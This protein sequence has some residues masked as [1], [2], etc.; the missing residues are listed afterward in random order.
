MGALPNGF[1]WA[2]GATP[3]PVGVDGSYALIL[4]GPTGT[5][6]PAGSVQTTSAL[7]AEAT[8]DEYPDSPEIERSEQATFTH[9][10][11]M[12][13][14]E[15]MN[16][17]QWYYRG[18]YLYDT[19]GNIYVCLSARFQRTKGGMCDVT[20]VSEAKNFDS[21]PDELEI[22]PVELGLNIMKHPRYF[23]AFLGDGYGSTT[24]KNNQQVIRLLQDYF[25]NP[26]W[27]NRNAIEGILVRSLSDTSYTPGTS[28][29]TSKEI[30]QY[31]RYGQPIPN[32]KI[33]GTALAKHAA[34]EIIQKYWRGEETPYIAGWQMTFSQYFFLPPFLHPGGVIQDPI[35]SN[36]VPDYLTSPSWPPN[37]AYQ[38]FDLM[39]QLNPQCYSSNGTVSGTS[40]ISW[41][42]K[43]DE[44][45]RQR[46]W[47][48]L[49]KTWIGTPVGYWDPDFYA[50]TA[51]PTL[52]VHYRGFKELTGK[53]T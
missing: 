21:P 43:A 31:V 50:A 51:R 45:E 37:D 47:F 42:R 4:G 29:D 40:S 20:I 8:V 23:Y 41:L 16:R 9:K 27:A 35:S 15:A 19:G 3:L 52:P 11:R 30:P 49:K 39:A 18:R 53:T 1:D 33:Y 26:S 36:Q 32:I 17:V 6:T 10:C 22:V 2:D 13:W 38:C 5:P 34:L 44:V 46:T 12:S 7:G 28:S 24:E 25:E 48:K 14:D